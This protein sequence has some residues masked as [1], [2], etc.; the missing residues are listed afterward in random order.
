[1]R[2]R[3][4]ANDTEGQR[5]CG[6]SACSL[7]LG[8]CRATLFDMLRFRQGSQ[9]YDTKYDTIIPQ[10]A[11]ALACH[12]T[13]RR[14]PRGDY[15]HRRSSGPRFHIQAPRGKRLSPGRCQ[16]QSVR[17]VESHHYCKTQVSGFLGF[18]LN[19]EFGEVVALV[20]ENRV[21]AHRKI[22]RYAAIRSVIEIHL[23]KSSELSSM[24]LQRAKRH[25][26]T[27]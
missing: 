16:L 10:L 8:C 5:S 23:T 11:V 2:H 20:P 27:R 22:L 14:V 3:S 12:T 24:S 26:C 6:F 4:S 9:G 7:P 13:V 15:Y 18:G 17:A 21:S 25:W 19:Q 1:M